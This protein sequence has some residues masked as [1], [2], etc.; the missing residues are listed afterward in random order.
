MRGGQAHDLIATP[1]DTQDGRSVKYRCNE[2]GEGYQVRTSAPS[3][4]VRLLEQM[5]QLDVPYANLA[6]AARRALF[7]ELVRRRFKWPKPFREVMLEHF[8]RWQAWKAS[9]AASRN[10]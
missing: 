1:E 4:R 9:L 10:Q 8:D 3:C 7:E 6:P 5:Q 2:C